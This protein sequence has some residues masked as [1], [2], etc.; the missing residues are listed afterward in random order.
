M[1]RPEEKKSIVPQTKS[2]FLLSLYLFCLSSPIALFPHLTRT[3]SLFS[4]DIC[5]SLISAKALQATD[6]SHC[7]QENFDGTA[8]FEV[9]RFKFWAGL[10]ECLLSPCGP[11]FWHR[12]VLSQFISQQFRHRLLEPTLVSRR[13]QLCGCPRTEPP[14]TVR[15]QNWSPEGAERPAV[16]RRHIRTK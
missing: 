4:I 6:S 3:L 1:A 15:G 14:S 9:D 16:L 8:P 2:R 10:P 5:H 11:C 13:L 12:P 7:T